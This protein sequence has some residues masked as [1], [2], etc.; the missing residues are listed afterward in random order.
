MENELERLKDKKQALSDHLKNA[1][2]ELPRTEVSGAAAQSRAG[3]K[4]ARGFGSSYGSL[5]KNLPFIRKSGFRKRP[6]EVR[7]L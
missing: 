2:Q 4:A 1:L 3:L 6:S 5:R 7:R